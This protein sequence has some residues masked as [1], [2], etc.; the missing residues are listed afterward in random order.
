MRKKRKNKVKKKVAQFKSYF[1]LIYR[2]RREKTKKKTWLW[3]SNDCQHVLLITSITRLRIIIFTEIILLTSPYLQNIFSS[4]P[5]LIILINLFV[6]FNL[7][8]WIRVSDL[9]IRDLFKSWYNQQMDSKHAKISEF[10]KSSLK[11]NRNFLTLSLFLE[12]LKIDF[13]CNNM[14]D[15]FK[16][17]RIYWIRKLLKYL[18]LPI[19]YQKVTSSKWLMALKFNRIPGNN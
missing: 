16:Q 2:N 1:H 17:P 12:S 13:W 6:S 19:P 18:H 4:L 7:N 8:R 14:L 15:Q 11:F 10:L 3:I 5:N 9:F